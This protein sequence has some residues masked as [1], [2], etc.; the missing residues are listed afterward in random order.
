[1]LVVEI[2]EK[3]LKTFARVGGLGE[4]FTTVGRLCIASLTGMGCFLVAIGD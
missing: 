2:I 3:D 1:M 4:T